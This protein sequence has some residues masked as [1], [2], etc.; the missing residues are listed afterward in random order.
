[1]EVGIFQI[2]LFAVPTQCPSVPS[3]YQHLSP[4]GPTLVA[5]GDIK[6]FFLYQN[7]NKDLP[8]ITC[9]YGMQSRKLSVVTN[10]SW[11]E[12]MGLQAIPR[13]QM[14]R[15]SP[16]S[17]YCIVQAAL[18]AVHTKTA[19]NAGG[20]WRPLREGDVYPPRKR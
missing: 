5:K 8:M 3:V 1:M 10:C 17:R 12:A 4:C 7:E 20:P 15:T 13:G 19:G 11:K 16:R 6:I 14:F 2:L 18:E 9:H